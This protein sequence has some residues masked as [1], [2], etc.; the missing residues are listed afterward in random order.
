ML[1]WLTLPRPFARLAHSYS[2]VDIPAEGRRDFFY[3]WLQARH[4]PFGR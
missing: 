1:V 3:A 2:E 4:G